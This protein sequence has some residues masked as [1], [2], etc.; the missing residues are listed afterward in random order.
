MLLTAALGLALAW[1][2]PGDAT[3][4]P[5]AC[6]AQAALR[7]ASVRFSAPAF[8]HGTPRLR[9]RGGSGQPPVMLT[10][11]PA[12][13]PAVRTGHT[14]AASLDYRSTRG[15]LTFEVLTHGP[16]GWRAW[17]AAAKAGRRARFGTLR[18]L[19]APIQGGIDRIAFGL[20]AQGAGEVQSR[21]FAL[22]DA[23]AHPQALAP[24]LPAATPQ[25]GVLAPGVPHEET[26]PPPNEEETPARTGRWR[27]LED[28]AQAR[29][30][31]AILLQ[32]GKLLVMAGSG[33]DPMAFKAGTFRSYLYDPAANTWKELITPKD[34]FCSGHVQLADGNVLILGGTSAYPPEPK[35]GEYPSTAYK[36]E[37]TSWIFNIHTDKYEN[38]PYD[39]AN[40]HNPTEPG[41]LLGGE[42]YPSATELGSGDVISFGGLDEQ[43]Q[44]DTK[45]NYF[46]DPANSADNGDLPGQWVGFGSGKLQQTYPWYWGEYPSM[47]LTADGRLFYDGS[48]VFGNG[49]ESTQQAPTGS[50]LYD[51]YCGEPPLGGG[52]GENP[53]EPNPDALVKGPNGTFARVTPTPGLRSPDMRDQSA[54]LLLPPAQSQKVMIMGGG[55]TYTTLAGSAQS[56]LDTTDEIDLREASP[57]WRPGPDLPQG[58][59]EDGSM[60]P[61]GAG[62]MYISAV[63]LPDGTVLETG[64]SE[65]VRADDVHEASI[66]DPQR[67]T[68]ASV[69]A[70]PVGRDYHSEALLLPDGRVI[71]LGS[72][73]VDAVSG[74]ARFETRV[75]IFEPPYLFKGPRPA[76]DAIDGLANATAADGTT[77]TTQ[78][79][80]GSEHVVG[81]SASAPIASA[82]L[83]RPG[84]VTHSSDPNQRE[85][86][87]PIVADA[88]GALTVKLTEN[89]NIAPPGYY[90]AFLLDAHGVPSVA[91]WVHVGPQGAPAP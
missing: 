75:S 53:N 54:S 37:N 63:A 48:H 62:K 44:G 7:G 27:V 56:A 45:T 60:E 40:P 88:N 85:V 67:D 90:M 80:Y 15:A 72:N 11:S 59:M 3:H 16:H 91:Q 73:P 1:P 10:Q 71:A 83:V 29:S 74:I 61:A 68:F 36:G 89:D 26:T 66:F 9:L 81:Y 20:L 52:P 4:G 33:N 50:S 46:V 32:N 21:G 34:V 86:A 13:A 69:A 79:E 43:G 8:T 41:P 49:L 70:D 35:P 31:H 28:S 38:V 24:A 14:Y 64:G 65:H 84:A 2:A 57:R 17:Y 78:W 51:F 47:I 77:Q 55:N 23:S 5:Q 39:E 42:W 18:V 30:V 87:L 76:I 82:V 25:A 22:I 19:L 58:R 6:Y 12:C